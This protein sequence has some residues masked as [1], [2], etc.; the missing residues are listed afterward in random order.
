MVPSN[1]YIIENQVLLEMFKRIFGKELSYLVL[2]VESVFGF[3]FQIF[4]RFDRVDAFRSL[5][6]IILFKRQ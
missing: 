1:I 6:F 3:F 2:I 4:V 5:M